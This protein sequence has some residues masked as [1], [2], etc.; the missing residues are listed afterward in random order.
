MLIGRGPRTANFELVDLL[1][2]CHQRIRQFS[3]L[4]I[5]IGELRDAPTSHLV[6]ACADVRRYF[7]QALPLHVADEEESLLPRLVGHDSRVDEALSVMHRQHSEHEPLLRELLGLCSRIQSSP[8]ELEGIRSPLH[9]L[10]TK[11]RGEFESHLILEET[12]IF[13][14]IGSMLSIEVQGDIIRELRARRDVPRRA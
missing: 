1:R 4:A 11:L 7:E 9:Q 5:A 12:D 8:G 10:A 2:E 6:E 13:P 3:D 14:R